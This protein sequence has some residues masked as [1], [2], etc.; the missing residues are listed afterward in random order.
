MTQIG[1]SQSFAPAAGQPGSTAI[2][3]DSSVF[4]AWANNCAV[5]RGFMQI[6]HPEFGFASFGTDN[7]GVG[8]A[9]G[10]SIDIVSLGD[11]GSAILT[12]NPPIKNGIGP[13]FAV[14]ENGFADH[15]MELAFVEVSSN[16][17]DFYR[18]P[19]YS[20]TPL[21]PQLTNGSFGNCSF[22]HNL[23]GKYRQ[24]FGTPFDLQDLDSIDNLDLNAITH[25][26]LIDVV[27][28]VDSTYGSVDCLGRLINDPWPTNFESGG[29]D[30]DGIG[31]I[32]QGEMNIRE[33][34]LT[35]TLS[36]NPTNNQLFINTSTPVNLQ[37]INA[38]GKVLHQAFHQSKITV[39]LEYLDAGIY[40]VQLTSGSK[41]IIE[42]ICKL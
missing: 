3:K 36:P 28:V 8:V 2:H 5:T 18:F 24:G 11:A 26:K 10:N 21:A 15:Y 40:Y 41:R 12:F 30:L 29:F 7:N 39:N 37:I 33:Q 4:V 23:A 1:W 9:E 17:I 13:D 31:V 22:V 14:F 6:D 27:G 25:V 20:E 34:K 38:Q 16:G 19:A 32:H 35:Y 42:K